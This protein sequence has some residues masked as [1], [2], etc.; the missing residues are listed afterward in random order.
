MKK[1]CSGNKPEVNI[2]MTVLRRA[3]VI[4]ADGR[5]GCRE[6][7]IV[8]Q[9]SCNTQPCLELALDLISPVDTDQWKVGD[10]ANFTWNGG[11][12]YGEVKIYMRLAAD[13]L[14]DIPAADLSTR[15][16]WRLVTGLNQPY[17][18]ERKTVLWTIPTGIAACPPP[19]Q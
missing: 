2:D 19:T 5:H 11:M 15:E 3:F 13:G 4:P 18:A 14:S 9:E 7:S 6:H 10:I 16:P 12:Q 17:S 1:Y 8:E